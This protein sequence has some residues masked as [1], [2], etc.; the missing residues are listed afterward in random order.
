MLNEFEAFNR[1]QNR[2]RQ[3]ESDLCSIFSA[4]YAIQNYNNI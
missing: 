1:I 2:S 4:K 3:S